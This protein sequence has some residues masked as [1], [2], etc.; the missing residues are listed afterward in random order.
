M[1]Q[2][3]NVF[4]AARIDMTYAYPSGIHPDIQPAHGTRL[5]RQRLVVVVV[6]LGEYGR[7]LYYH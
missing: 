1:V 4:R 3:V 5:V 6:I 7:T 2:C